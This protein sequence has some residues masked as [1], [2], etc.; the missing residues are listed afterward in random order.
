MCREVNKASLSFMAALVVKCD[1]FNLILR[2]SHPQF[3][4]S[5]HM[6]R[7][8]GAS[9]KFTHEDHKALCIDLFFLTQWI[10]NFESHY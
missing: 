10:G 4:I 6:L 7:T 9:G 1:R 3:P 2:D 8:V 5:S